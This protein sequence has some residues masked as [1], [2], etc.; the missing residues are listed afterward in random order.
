MDR[1]TSFGFPPAHPGE[2]LRED[3]L[4]ALDISKAAFADHLGI[5]RQT[6][7]SVLNGNQSIG[8]E[9]AC[10]LGKALG[11]GARF[12]LTLQ[13]QYDIWVFEQEGCNVAPLPFPKCA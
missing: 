10:R 7:Y 13:M 9:L 1:S 2:Y 6:L 11:N 4:P 3:V 12:W 8:T 5:S